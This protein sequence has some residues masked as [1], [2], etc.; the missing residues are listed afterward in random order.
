M[1]ARPARPRKLTHATRKHRNHRRRPGPALGAHRLSRHCWH[2]RPDDYQRAH[3]Q[4]QL[5]L[6]R[7]VGQPLPP[8]GHPRGGVDARAHGG[9]HGARHHPRRDHGRH[10]TLTQP[11]VAL[12]GD[13]LHLV[14]PRHPNLHSAH[15]LGP[16]RHALHHHHGGH[17]VDGDRLF[18]H[19]PQPARARRPPADHVHLRRARPRAERGRLPVR[20]RPLRPQ[21]RRRRAGGSR[22]GARHVARPGAPPDRLPASHARHHPP[23]RATRRSPCS[24]PPRS[25]PPS[26]SPST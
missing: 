1:P 14:L 26:P 5:A 15:L 19:Q 18:H 9:R 17:S 23:P 10:A 16:D 3:H 7:G 8:R 2:L 22:Q 6:G 25:S 21:L 20:D 24:R 4:P 11:G 12:G 13:G